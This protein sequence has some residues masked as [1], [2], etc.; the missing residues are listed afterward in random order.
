MQCGMR[1]LMLIRS[2]K[3]KTLSPLDAGYEINKIKSP[4]PVQATH[5]IGTILATYQPNDLVT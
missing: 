3:S 4:A 2:L 5:M 1:G